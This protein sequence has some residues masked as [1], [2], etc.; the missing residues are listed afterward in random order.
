MTEEGIKKT[1]Q[2]G[3]LDGGVRDCSREVD[4]KASRGPEPRKLGENEGKNL[5]YIKT[6]EG[7]FRRD[8][9]NPYPE[10][11]KRRLQKNKGGV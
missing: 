4:L 8:K 3:L 7:P 10:G 5:R 1:F 9:Q 2:H 11:Q 6:L